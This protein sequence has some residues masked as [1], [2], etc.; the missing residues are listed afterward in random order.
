MLPP[1]RARALVSNEQV[2]LSDEAVAVRVAE[3]VDGVV[4][5][6]LA[7]WDK[8]EPA[9]LGG[10]VDRVGL[11][12]EI[13]LM[14]AAA[15]GSMSVAPATIQLLSPDAN[16]GE[17]RRCGRGGHRGELDTARRGVS[18]M[19]CSIANCTAGTAVA[20]HLGRPE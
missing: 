2:P 16:S 17:L 5:Q 7:V 4:K 15:A 10:D 12:S 6:L 14:A 20:L 9:A 3:L 13:G 8:L 18:R 19:P 11:G 1:P